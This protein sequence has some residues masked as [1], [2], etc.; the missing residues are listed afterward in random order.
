PSAAAPVLRIDGL[1]KGAAPLDGAWQFHLGD[2]PAWAQPAADDAT[3]HNGWA[4][5]LADGPWGTQGHANY[6]G[7]AWYRRHIDIT[8]APGSPASLAMM[9]PA[10]D[11]V[12]ELYWNGQPMGR[13]GSFPPHL[14][15]YAAV[16]PQTWGLGPV[17][18]GVLAVRVFKVPLASNDDGTAGGFEAPPI[19]GSPE[20]IAAAKTQTDYKW[21]RASQF[22][23]AL[24][25]LYAIASLLSFVAWLRDRRQW[26]L[27]WM[28]AFTFMP[29]LELLLTGM[30]LEV[31]N[32]WL[33][34]IVQF[35]I[36]LREISQWFLLIWLLQLH[37]HPRLVRW[38]RIV[39]VGSTIA[40]ALDGAL[41]FFYPAL[42]V[43]H[44]QITDA[45]LTFFILPGEA[46]PILL[47]L[48]AIVRRQHLDSARW[49]VAGFALISG[50]FYAVS[51][52]AAQGVRFTHWTLA[53][54]MTSSHLMILGI[55]ISAQPCLRTLLFLSI[56]YAVA[57]YAAMDRRRRAALE[58]EFENAREI[59]QVLVPETLPT[60]PGFTLS[61]SYK[62]AL[63][64]GGDFFQIVALDDDST[65]VILG[66]VSGKGLRAAMAVSLIVGAVR[67]IAETTS[68]P[69]EILAH[70]NRH[71]FG[72]LQGGFATCV[73]LKLSRDGTCVVASAG[74]PAPLLN[75]REI[76]LAGALPLGLVST[77]DYADVSVPL[78][79]GDHLAL[80]TDG[81]LEARAS[82]GE[83]YGFERIYTLFAAHANAAHATEAA[84]AF[85]QEDDITVLTLQRASAV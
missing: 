76:A 77:V 68:S 13:F 56:V 7:Y 48:Y 17:R 10:I 54:N 19:L 36:Q 12:Y 45:V 9:I 2:D 85:G 64:V 32:I 41:G 42:G 78:N 51:N 58:L 84:V 25:S 55:A 37:D 22:R 63:Q 79:P 43:A 27:F 67:S 40:G 57:S 15:Y 14:D 20:A 70:L 26:L 62:P 73:A 72:R 38:V 30:R 59:Q 33:T 1:G 8:M 46:I 82:N 81:L 80:Y 61:S 49:L 5:I 47:V 6:S 39:A 18:S 4:Q 31:S 21:L 75:E 74:H 16:P 28:M 60:I 11:D 66:D 23:F 44:F 69:A 52:I 65:L 24:T 34:F 83:L 53:A 50:T 71:L 35:T 3:G 29:V